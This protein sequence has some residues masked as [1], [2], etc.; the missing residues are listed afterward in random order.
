[1]LRTEGSAPAR[2]KPAAGAGRRRRAILSVAVLVLMLGATSILTGSAGR[3]GAGS[4]RTHGRSG[5]S[6]IGFAPRSSPYGGEPDL[7]RHSSVPRP[8]RNAAV[9]FVRDY[10]E[11]SEGRLAKL[12]AR[13][14]TARVIVTL[15]RRGRAAGVAA[16]GV[17]GPVR[18]ASDGRRT[19][20]VTSRVGNF[21]IRRHRSLWL[22]VSLPGD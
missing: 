17:A 2:T 3:P 15:E 7:A 5:H 16:S 10:G 1:M 6:P 9:R 19:Y 21:I 11:W 14:G 4:R 8:V 12:P 13:D 22:V 18:L 20:I